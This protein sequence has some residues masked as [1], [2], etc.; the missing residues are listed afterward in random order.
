[1]IT[2]SATM[3]DCGVCNGTAKIQISGGTAPYAS[4]WLLGGAIVGTDTAIT[5]LCAGL[6]SAVVQDANGCLAHKPVAIGDIG[7]E[8]L[9]TPSTWPHLPH[10]LQRS[11]GSELQ[12][13]HSGLHRGVVQR[14]GHRPE[15]V[16]RHH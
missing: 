5:G 2:V 8:V 15:P 6:Y 14:H 7:G 13:A 4:A 3:S 9:Q 16:R 11:I 10:G 12:L 1:M